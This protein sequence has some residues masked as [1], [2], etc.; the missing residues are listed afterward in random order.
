MNRRYLLDTSI[1]SDLAKRP[2]GPVTQRITEQGVESIATSLVVACEIR[3]GLVKSGSPR[4]TENM[5]QVLDSIEILPLEH[6]V[7][8]HYAEIR[9]ALERAGTPIGPN[10]LLIAAHARALGMILVTDNVREFSR[11][12]G[13]GV[14]NWLA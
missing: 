10:D 5:N 4:L 8:E 9:N 13:L 12:E 2:A 1:L 7:D 3:F 11:V 6:P 14:E